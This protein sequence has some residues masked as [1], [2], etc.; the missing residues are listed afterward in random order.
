[1]PA[2][3]ERSRS[4]KGGH[5][6]IFFSEPVSA[7][8]ARKVGCYIL[9]K[10]LER[11]YQIGLD[12]YD[13]LFPNQ[14]T[15]PKGGFGN[16]IALPLQKGPRKEGNSLFL[17][18]NFH[19]YSDQWAFLSK[20]NSITKSELEAIAQD[21]T[22]KGEVVGAKISQTSEEEVEDPRTLPPSGRKKE[23]IIEG[24]LPPQVNVY[25]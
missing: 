25:L 4:G 9:T 1:M 18:E 8:V 17:D 12:S 14:D 20:V 2:I 6:W 7:F 23:L 10:T 15:L 3:L 21:A 16:L 24:P 5:V 13:R 22:R 19:P 11:R